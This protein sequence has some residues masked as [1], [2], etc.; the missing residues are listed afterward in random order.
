VTSV[1]GRGT[2]GYRALELLPLSGQS[3][4]STRSDIWALGCIIHEL[5]TGRPAFLDDYSVTIYTNASVDRPMEI[6][7]ECKFWRHHISEFLHEL[8]HKDAELRPDA[9]GASDIIS[10]YT[11][12]SDFRDSNLLP[13]NEVYISYSEYKRKARSVHHEDRLKLLLKIL[14]NS[15][16]R[17]DPAVVRGYMLYLEVQM[18]DPRLW[19]LPLRPERPARQLWL[20]LVDEMI[21]ASWHTEAALIYP[22]CVFHRPTTEARKKHI[23]LWTTHWPMRPGSVAELPCWAFHLANYEQSST[24]VYPSH[25]VVM[26][27]NTVL[28]DYLLMG[29]AT[30]LEGVTAYSKIFGVLYIGETMMSTARI[31]FE[32]ETRLIALLII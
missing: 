10:G 29:S 16:R 6:S 8:L 25:V 9:E 18:K 2:P 15:D 7:F 19:D 14:T 20:Q 23:W 1:Y 22:H 4:Y 30:D 31:M 17:V 32:G 11:H 5:S 28:E 21:R 27:M 12:L 13:A 3:K 24:L 26:D